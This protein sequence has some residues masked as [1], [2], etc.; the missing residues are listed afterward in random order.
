M[1]V[2]FLGEKGERKKTGCP[3]CGTRIRVSNT[4]SYT[5]RMILPSGRVMV[6]VLNREYEVNEKE[7]QFLLDYHY[8]YNNEEMHPFVKRD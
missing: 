1:I 5:K 6:F 3:V 8:T 2:K 4:I 7:G